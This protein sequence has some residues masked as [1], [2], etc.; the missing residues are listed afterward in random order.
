MSLPFSQ[1]HFESLWTNPLWKRPRQTLATPRRD[2]QLT[3]LR[4][5]TDI[6]TQD[7]E[8]RVAFEYQMPVIPY[9]AR[10]PAR[11]LG[12]CLLHAWRVRIGRTVPLRVLELLPQLV[13]VLAV[14]RKRV[15]DLYNA[16]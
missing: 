7:L 4:G 6:G 10:L 3:D 16:I 9:S 14:R 11:L 15:P 2:Y 1:E 12:P 13:L 8:S 5:R